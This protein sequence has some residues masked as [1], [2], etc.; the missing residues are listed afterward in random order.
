MRERSPFDQR[1]GGPSKG[2]LVA[3]VGGTKTAVARVDGGTVTGRVER[4]TPSKADPAETVE[5]LAS[6][7]RP[8]LSPGEPVGVAVTGHVVDGRVRP[9]NEATLPRWH[10][11]P[12]GSMLASALGA[13]VVLLNDAHAAALGEAN[14]GAG[15]G[16]DPMLFV[17]LSTGLGA[18][19]VMAGLPVTG[20][21]GLAGHLGF[22]RHVAGAPSDDAEEPLEAWASGTAL[23][24]HAR[25]EWGPTADARTV[26]ERAR[27]G[28]DRAAELLD[29]VLHPVARALT[30]V[31]WLVDPQRIVIGG[32]LGLAPGV[33]GRLRSMVG[34]LAGREGLPVA[35]L[36]AASLGADAGLVGMACR[37]ADAPRRAAS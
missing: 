35:D 20:A 8:R 21:H 26:V 30:D 2:V 33:L 22:W 3:D 29:R 9:V 10:D 15:A 16:A 11:V 17:T 36:T 32:G 31:R 12:L 34:T 7:L 5:L 6:M 24:R 13:S 18:G 14:H 23:S 28:D 27:E 37:L 25:H 19:L 4:P 1:E